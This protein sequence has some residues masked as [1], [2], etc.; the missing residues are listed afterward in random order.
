MTFRDQF[1]LFWRSC[2]LQ[3]CWN[4]ERMQSLGLSFALNPWLKR[5]YPRSDER[6]EALLRHQE[7]FNTQPTMACLVLGMICALEEDIARAPRDQREAKILKLK[8]LKA[9]VASALAGIGDALFWGALQPFCAALAAALGLFL[10]RL[11]AGAAAFPAMA[12]VYLAA[13]NAPALFLRWRGLRWG[14]EWREQIAVKLKG[15]RW[16]AW[17]LRLR[18]MGLVLAL[19]VYALIADASWPG[20]PAPQPWLGWLALVA[21]AAAGFSPWFS[22]YRLYGLTALAGALAA[23]AGWAP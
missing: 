22:A 2:L 4:F 12:A 17:I 6:C 9:A 11:G 5:C 20:A 23:A 19:G 16:Q 18:G 7:Y 1:S 8:A 10:W 3:S 13:Y 21:Y 14:Y 15:F